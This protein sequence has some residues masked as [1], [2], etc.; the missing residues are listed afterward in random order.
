MAD[1]RY[2]FGSQLAKRLDYFAAP[3]S[4]SHYLWHC[5]T[6]LFDLIFFENEYIDL[7]E[8][9]QRMEEL[10]PQVLYALKLRNDG[11]P[12]QP[13]WINPNPSGLHCAPKGE[14]PHPSLVLVRDPYASV[15][16]FYHTATERWGQQVT[17]RVSWI[18]ER[19]REYESFFQTSFAL[20]QKDP[21][22]TCLIR[23]EDLRTGPAELERLVE[24]A[25]VTPKLSP[26]FVFWL[27]QFDRMTKPGKRTF[28]RSGNNGAW[29]E[30]ASWQEALAEAEVPDFSAFGYPRP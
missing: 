15:Y 1:N 2:Y 8:A 27:T 4:G 26:Q 22:K 19:F 3:R 10:D 17:D 20:Q 12:Y 30:D 29:K 6:G 7:P 9:V 25:G 24:F 21:V 18:A 14:T 13:I 28:Y 5:I 23:F 11:V 16:S